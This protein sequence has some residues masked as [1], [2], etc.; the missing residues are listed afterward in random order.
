MVTSEDL[1]LNKLFLAK[2]S[3]SEHQARDAV[4]LLREAEELDTSHLEYWA[5]ALSVNELLGRQRENERRNR[6]D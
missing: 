5:K 1:I 2:E 4:L 6:E 3:G